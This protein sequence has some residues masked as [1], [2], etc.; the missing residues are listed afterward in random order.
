MWNLRTIIDM[1][2]GRSS[3]LDGLDLKEEIH[4]LNHP[5][6]FVSIWMKADFKKMD[7]LEFLIKYTDMVYDENTSEQRRKDIESIIKPMFR[8]IAGRNLDT[9]Q[10]I[11]FGIEQA[12]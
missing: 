3:Q 7:R 6:L 1:L 9:N 5:S 10:L 2:K 8:E 12:K 11:A 4:F